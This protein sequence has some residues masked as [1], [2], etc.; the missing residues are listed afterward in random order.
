MIV[1]AIT[2]NPQKVNNYTLVTTQP[3]ENR[4]KTAA[5]Y[6]VHIAM[7]QVAPFDWCVWTGSTVHN[8]HQLIFVIGVRTDFNQVNVNYAG[9]PYDLQVV[10]YTKNRYNAPRPEWSGNYRRL[11]LEELQTWVKKDADV[12]AF[13]EYYRGSTQPLPSAF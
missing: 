3:V 2:P 13:E 10:T 11:T 5:E 12:Q 8:L 9:N 6:G 1:H 4:I 7:L